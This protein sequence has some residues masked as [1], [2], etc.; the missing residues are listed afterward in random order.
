MESEDPLED[1]RVA[2]GERFD[3]RMVL[4]GR[5]LDARARPPL[6]GRGRGGA[7][8]Q[9]AHQADQLAIGA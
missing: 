3:H 4:A 2:R 7:A 8:A 1:R 5:L 6:A 9:I